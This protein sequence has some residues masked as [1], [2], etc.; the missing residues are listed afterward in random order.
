MSTNDDVGTPA[1]GGVQKHAE[2]SP[3]ATGKNTDDD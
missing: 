3:H 2:Q 1:V